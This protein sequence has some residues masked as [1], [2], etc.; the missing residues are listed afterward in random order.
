MGKLQAPRRPWG[1]ALVPAGYS[2]LEL[3]SQRD[4]RPGAHD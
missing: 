1:L 4:N 3:G 2:T